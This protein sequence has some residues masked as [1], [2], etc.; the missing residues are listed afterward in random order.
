MTEDVGWEHGGLMSVYVHADSGAT[1]PGVLLDEV[2]FSFEREDTGID[3]RGRR[4]YL[5]TVNTIDLTYGPG[6]YWIGVRHPQAGGA[7][8][9]YWVSDNGDRKNGAGVTA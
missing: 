4:Y 1:S 6:R 2:T 8:T 7:G 5:H 3:I 9:A